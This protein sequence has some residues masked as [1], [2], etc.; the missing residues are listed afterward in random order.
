[1]EQS[2]L[3]FGWRDAKESEFKKVTKREH[4]VLLLIAD[5]ASCREIS[6]KLFIHVRSVETIRYRMKKK[7]NLTNRVEL[8]RFGLKYEEWDKTLK[9]LK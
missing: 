4:D 8:I 3:S 6:E 1:M 9:R 2:G 5:G 7:F